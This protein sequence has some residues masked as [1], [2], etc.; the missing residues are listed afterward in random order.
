[1]LPHAPKR[2]E[3]GMVLWTPS[4]HVK[5]AGLLSLVQIAACS[6]PRTQLTPPVMS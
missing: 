4:P 6:R 5:R 3:A 1:M 2:F